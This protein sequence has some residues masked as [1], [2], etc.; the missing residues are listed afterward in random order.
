MKLFWFSVFIICMGGISHA[1]FNLSKDSFLQLGRLRVYGESGWGQSEWVTALRCKSKAK[2]QDIKIS[3]KSC[4]YAADVR[5]NEFIDLPPGRY[6]LVYDGVNEKR[7]IPA[8]FQF[9]NIFKR[10]K[11]QVRLSYISL[12]G[13]AH[14]EVQK[15]NLIRIKEYTEPLIQFLAFWNRS[16]LVREHDLQKNKNDNTANFITVFPGQYFFE[17]E[18]VAGDNSRHIYED[19]QEVF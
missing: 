10:K 7:K 2:D 19:F 9:V 15:V 13:I 8:N 17:A 3:A 6:L 5:L 12:E 11:L 18:I 4:R 16:F 14:G 1:E